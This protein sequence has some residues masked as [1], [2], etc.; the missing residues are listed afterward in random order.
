MP[1]ASST[2]PPPSPSP[3]EAPV[4]SPF[5]L[6]PRRR[7]VPLSL[8]LL[9]IVVAGIY[10]ASRRANIQE[11]AFRELDLNAELKAGQLSDWRN[12]R[13][14]EAR[15]FMQLPAVATD[16]AA[17]LANPDSPRAQLAVNQW[18][19]AMKGGEHYEVV[20]CLDAQRRVVL[21]LPPTD[22]T[23]CPHVLALPSS[24]LAGAGPYFS[25]L[26]Q[27]SPLSPAHF[28]LVAPIAPPR[29]RWRRPDRAPALSHQPRAEF[30]PPVAT[31]AG[32]HPHRRNAARPKGRR[33]GGF[34]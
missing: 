23:A 29:S 34:P 1:P 28:D 9:I 33:R 7:I 24:T 25:D 8:A 2:A 27:A 32:A 5:P 6:E 12:A 26:H 18:L 19:S 3:G 20:L 11:A 30:F 15:F 13:L 21:S 14:S 4:A 10:H 16:V 17:L 22:T 31:L